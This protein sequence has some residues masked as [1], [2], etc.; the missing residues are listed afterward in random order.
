M[1]PG[2]C[3]CDVRGLEVVL[4]SSQGLSPR[5]QVPRRRHPVLPTTRLG[6]WAA[7]LAVGYVVLQFAWSFLGP[8]GAFPSFACGVAGG[9]VALLAILRRGERALTVFAAVL[10]LLSVIAFVLAELLIGHD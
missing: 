4:V 8:L 7:G 6:R 3:S 5:L 10:P 9:V 1:R 2:G